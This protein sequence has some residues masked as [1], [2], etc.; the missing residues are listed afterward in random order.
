MAR[1]AV[2][3]LGGLGR[4]QA[5]AC[6]RIDGAEVVAGA[7]VSESIRSEFGD[8]LGVP[9][10]D[11]HE[12]LLDAESVDAAFIATP[13]TLHYEQAVAFL[14]ADCH[15]HLEK[16]MVVRTA[17]GVDLIERAAAAGLALQVGYQRHF[18]PGYRELRDVVQERIGAVHMASCYLG[19]DWIDGQEG[20]WRT[21]PG[22]S[23]GGQLSDSGSHLLDALLWT[24]DARPV[25]VAAVMDDQGHEVDV[26]SAVAATLEGPD[27][28]ITASIGV[29]GDGPGF[30]E[31][32]HFRGTEG[33]VSYRDDTITLR[34]SDGPTYTA[35]VESPGWQELTTE[36]LR[37]FVEAARGERD[38]AVPGSQALG[39]TALTEAAYE[40]RDGGQTVDAATRLPD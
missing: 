28:V 16:P 13:H 22:L 6:E 31:G 20:T 18:H 19:Q 3:G 33:V 30:Q 21:D 38:V 29:S 27:G 10:Y 39:V 14:E 11:S 36:K 35:T 32:L 5:E 25:T 37:A 26:N 12:A 2:V 15:V 17:H 23:G 34:R 8:A 40:A 24:T 4:L 1:I 9:T 7:D